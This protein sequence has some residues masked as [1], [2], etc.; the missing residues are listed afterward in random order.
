M[1]EPLTLAW[2]GSRTYLHG[3]DLFNAL[4]EIAEF[5][6]GDQ[7]AF[8]SQLIFKRFA[9]TALAVTTDEPATNVQT[10]GKARLAFA[11]LGTGTN[12]WI[13]ETGD[14]VTTRRPFDEDDLVATAVVDENAITLS[15]RSHYSPI[16]E[17]IALTKKLNYALSPEVSGRWV[18]GQIDLSCR[19]DTDHQI[20]RIERKNIVGNRFS[21]NEIRLNEKPV[22]TIRF[23]VGS[24]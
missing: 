12:L 20:T 4:A 1:I 9:R 11:K 21:L 2:K 15:K 23:I 7:S 16:E 13:I 5:V 17:I 10:I 18:F 19:L 8:V 22:G 3:S 6:S 14:E 24:P